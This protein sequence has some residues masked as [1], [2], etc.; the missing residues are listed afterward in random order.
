MVLANLTAVGTD[1]AWQSKGNGLFTL[2]VDSGNQNFAQFMNNM[3]AGLDITPDAYSSNAATQS[4]FWG[5]SDITVQSISIVALDEDAVVG[6]WQNTGAGT[7]NITNGYVGANLATVNYQSI[8]A[9]QFG[10]QL[11]STDSGIDWTTLLTKVMT[12]A[13]VV[14]S[15]MYFSFESLG[16]WLSWQ[17]RLQFL[18]MY[19]L[20]FEDGY[21]TAVGKLTAQ[22]GNIFDM[23]TI[24]AE[25]S[26]TAKDNTIRWILQVLTAYNVCS[27]SLDISSPLEAANRE[28]TGII[29]QLKGGQVSLQEPAAYRD[30][31]FYAGAEIVSVKYQYRG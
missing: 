20:C 15:P 11:T 31:E 3:Y 29:T 22:I 27:A 8:T 25:T 17:Q 26:E 23:A 9:L 14:V 13:T 21:R 1:G 28:V 16:L 4:A 24:L 19:P 7:L 5:Q 18:N 2:E 6:Q 30:D 10:V 12:A